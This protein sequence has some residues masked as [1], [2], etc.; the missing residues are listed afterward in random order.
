VS[1]YFR[2]APKAGP[3]VSPV[4][5]P[6]VNLGPWV[7]S[8]DRAFYDIEMRKAVAD[9][10]GLG[11]VYDLNP[12]GAV[13]DLA[14]RPEGRE[15]AWFPEAPVSQI[16]PQAQDDD[17]ID[18]FEEVLGPQA[19]YQLFGSLAVEQQKSGEGDKKFEAF[20]TLLPEKLRK[21]VEATE[22][23]V[24]KAVAPPPAPVI[25]QAPPQKAESRT[26]EYVAIGLGVLAA[27]G[28]GYAVGR[29]SA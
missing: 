8:K 4:F 25:I 11:S 6:T 19:T 16:Y 9:R 15:A 23:A 28:V 3:W 20:K 21:K 5:V 27:F 29:R 26:G 22:A 24:K 14:P 17:D 2:P 18:L 12:D 13:Y 1:S 10:W 7:R